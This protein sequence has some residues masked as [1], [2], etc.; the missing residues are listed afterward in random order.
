MLIIHGRRNS[1]NVQKV[2]WALN[3]M[4]VSYERLDVGGE[5]GIVNEPPYLA[6]NP[7]A[8][9]PTMEEDGFIPVSYTHLTLPTKA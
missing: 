6:M 1:S 9:V 4:E 5:F 8:R 7:N 2:V 3:E